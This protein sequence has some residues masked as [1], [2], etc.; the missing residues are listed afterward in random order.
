MGN[1]FLKGGCYHICPECGRKF[2][3]DFPEL[4]RYRRY[5]KKQ[6]GIRVYLCSWHCLN[7]YD[8][9][10]GDLRKRKKKVKNETA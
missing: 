5:K 7:S 6:Y 10:N 3:I 9:K 8:A 1:A 2:F 4:W